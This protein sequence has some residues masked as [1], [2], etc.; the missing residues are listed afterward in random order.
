MD[1]PEDAVG[2]GRPRVVVG[3]DGSAMSD[4]AVA[5]ADR[6]ATATG[7]TIE[8]IAAWDLPQFLAAEVPLPDNYH[9]EADAAHVAEQARGVLT[10]P[11]DR[12]EVRV[13]HGSARAAL[14]EAGRGADLV[15]VGSRGHSTLA[16]LMLGSVSAYCV[17]H[18]PV[19]VVVVR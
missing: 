5:W 11:A 17:Q 3:V 7:G 1:D 12:V 18:A 9:P 6:Y 2:T 14:V 15:V 8:L 4:A 13:V 19:P 10:L 16:G